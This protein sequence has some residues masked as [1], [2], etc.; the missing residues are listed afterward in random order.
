MARLMGAFLQ[1]LVANTTKNGGIKINRT[2]RENIYACIK[3]NE[4]DVRRRRK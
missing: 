2:L 3:V 4:G 1:L